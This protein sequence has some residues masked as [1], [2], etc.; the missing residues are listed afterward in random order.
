[1]ILNISI[2]CCFFQNQIS[3]A[4]L[5]Y[6]QQICGQTR[7]P[8]K[9]SYWRNMIRKWEKNNKLKI[10]QIIVQYNFNTC[11]IWGMFSLYF[12]KPDSLLT[13][14]SYTSWQYD[15]DI[16]SEISFIVTWLHTDVVFFCVCWMSYLYSTIYVYQFFITSL[17]LI[18]TTNI[19]KELNKYKNEV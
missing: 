13:Y 18:K 5:T 4:H 12:F 9:K 17:S 11:F 7:K 16:K 19:P 14:I 6:K 2:M 15:A 3:I 10:Q 1:M 8:T